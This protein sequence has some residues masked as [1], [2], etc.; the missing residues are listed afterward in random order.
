[1]YLC[2]LF[3]L[4]P[5]LHALLFNLSSVS[6]LLHRGRGI[7]MLT[8]WRP[9]YIDIFSLCVSSSHLPSSVLLILLRLYSFLL[10]GWRAHAHSWRPCILM[11]ILPRVSRLLI[12]LSLYYS[13]SLLFIPPSI[14][15]ANPY[16][17]V[18]ARY[19][20]LLLT[21]VPVSLTYLPVSR[22]FFLRVPLFL[23]FILFLCLCA[24]D[25]Q[26]PCLPVSF[27]SAFDFFFSLWNF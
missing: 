3:P 16:T 21:S 5:L 19:R 12:Y 4:A 9:R 27:S 1:M 7:L 11:I 20:R 26:I 22:L 10:F 8:P 15:L 25:V 14:W 17:C 24:L 18:E 23:L 13:S 2:F 6:V